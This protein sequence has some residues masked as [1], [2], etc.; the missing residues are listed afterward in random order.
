VQGT[1]DAVVWSASALAGLGSGQ[2]FAGGGYA[3][4]AVVGGV[5]AL[6]PLALLASRDGR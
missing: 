5:L 4:V 1:V 6:L 3:L 2:L